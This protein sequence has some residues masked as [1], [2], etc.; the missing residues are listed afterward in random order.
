MSFPTE[1]VIGGIDKPRIYRLEDN[2]RVSNG[3]IEDALGSEWQGTGFT[4]VLA[5]AQT[6]PI[7]DAPLGDQVLKV[8]DDDGG[9]WERAF[10]SV[11]YDAALASKS[12]L[13][14]LKAR[15]SGSNH[16]VDIKLGSA[17]TSG[18]TINNEVKL[19]VPLDIDYWRIIH[20]VV[21]FSAETDEFIRLELGGAIETVSAT[22]I[23]FFDD[24]RVY[25]I[26]ET[27]NLD[28]PNTWQQPWQE[29]KIADFKLVGGKR[30]KI[31]DG[32]R[33]NLNMAYQFNSATEQQKIIEITE[34]GLN[35]VIPHIDNLFGSLMQWN[36]DYQN[37]YFFDRYLGHNVVVALQAVE[38]ERDKPREIGTDYTVA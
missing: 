34:S 2:N 26:F 10:Q 11:D 25:E 15:A 36:S 24:I 27:Y 37:V 19:T 30:R 29:E 9:S 35:F 21:T 18:G 20:V 4:R 7:F 12:F 33:Y 31:V 17:T 16:S 32:W 5:S 38:L 28:Q 1:N 13:L 8:D 3:S 23:A 6:S 14:T 22:G